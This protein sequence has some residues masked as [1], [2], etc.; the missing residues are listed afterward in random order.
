QW[1]A[2]AKDD[3]SRA[4]WWSHVGRFRDQLGDREAAVAAY[5]HAVRLDP[6]GRPGAWYGL[7]RL[8]AL[9][10]GQRAGL[11]QRAPPPASCNDHQV[12]LLRAAAVEH[13]RAGDSDS[14]FHAY[15]GA[16]RVIAA[17]RP[18]DADAASSLTDEIIEAFPSDV[19]KGATLEPPHDTVFIVGMPRSGT[20][21][22]ER[23]LSSHPALAAG[24]ER[25]DLLWLR[26]ELARLAA[27]SPGAADAVSLLTGD[28]AHDFNRRYH[29]RLAENLD[30]QA[31]I[32]DKMPSNYLRLGWLPLIFPGARI[33]HCRRNPLDTLVSCYITHFAQGQG[34]SYSFDGLVAAYEQYERIMAH[35]RRVMPEAMCEVEYES[36]VHDPEPEVRRMLAHCGL[37]WDPACLAFHEQA[38]AVRTASVWQV[39]KPISTGSV[40]RWR[41]Y[42]AHLGPLI[43]AFPEA[44]RD[45]GER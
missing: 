11:M 31:R 37:D 4:A 3:I 7:A 14:A 5:N 9:N 19:L 15:A 27:P 10:A 12:P 38:G 39:R 45:T 13:D 25:S 29:E 17:K 18:F 6:D 24:G 8:G 41:R 28:A 21:L 20:T 23:I 44:A 42:E 35:W 22:V 1:A 2:V 33:I 26:R 16:N 36:L 32:T 40:G 34:F 43:E 30:R